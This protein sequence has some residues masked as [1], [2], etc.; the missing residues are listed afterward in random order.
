M[1]AVD[2]AAIAEGYYQGNAVIN[3]WPMLPSNVAEHTPFEE[4]TESVRELWTYNLQK[5]KELL[6]DSGD[7]GTEVWRRWA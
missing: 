5:A 7:F 2:K 4:M 1:L 3:T 6:A